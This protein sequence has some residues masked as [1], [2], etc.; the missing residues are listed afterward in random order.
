MVP[1]PADFQVVHGDLKP[2]PEIA[3]LHE[4]LEALAGVRGEQALVGNEQ[5]GVCL[6]VG[7]THPAAQ[8]VHLGQTEAVRAVDDDRIGG[9]D[10]E[11]GFND[12]GAHQQIDVPADKPDHDALQVLLCHLAVGHVEPDLR[13]QFLGGCAPYVDAVDGVVNEE[14]LP[15]ARC[16]SRRMASAMTSWS[17][18]EM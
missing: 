2:E 13:N 11:T 17:N 1:P 7:S 6:L 16:S 14:D 12:G 9:R 15:L 8:L 4:D 10:V 18:S 3:V 5:V